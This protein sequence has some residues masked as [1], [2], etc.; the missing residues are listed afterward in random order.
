MPLYSPLLALCIL[1]IR[2]GGVQEQV[3]KFW[4]RSKGGKVRGKQRSQVGSL[5][6]WLQSRNRGGCRQGE[7]RN[8]KRRE[9][10]KSYRSK[11]AKGGGSPRAVALTLTRTSGY[12]KPPLSRQHDTGLGLEVDQALPNLDRS[13]A[14]V[15]PNLA[16]FDQIWPSLTEFD[17]ISS[18]SRRNFNGI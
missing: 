6:E 15:R 8:R 3:R 2:Q 14:E 13:S 5:M 12:I 10:G 1:L 18:E 4:K 7:E 17:R 11:D 16:K 9:A